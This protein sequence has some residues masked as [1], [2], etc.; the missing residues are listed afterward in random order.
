MIA[1]I[2]DFSFNCFLNYK[3]PAGDFTMKLIHRRNF[4]ALFVILLLLCTVGIAAVFET[5]NSVERVCLTVCANGIQ[6]D[7]Y[8]FSKGEVFYAFL[9]SYAELDNTTISAPSGFK[10]VINGCMYSPSSTL[11]QLSIGQRYTLEIKSWGGAVTTSAPLIIEKSANI[12]ALAI[13][14]QDGVLENIHNNKEL[15]LA[16]SCTMI[17]ED[18]VVDYDGVFS[19]LTGRGNS[20]WGESEKKAYNIQF[21]T[22][23]DLLGMG[24]ATKYCLVSN[25]CDQSNLRNKI[26]YD[27]SQ[28][29]NLQYAIDSM[30]VD[31]YIDSR[32]YGLYLLTESIEVGHNRVDIHNLEAQT[33]ELNHFALSKYDPFSETVSEVYRQGVL[34]P[35]IPEDVTGGYL[36]E[37]EQETRMYTEASG[38]IT[39]GGHSFSVKSPKYCSPE[40]I[41]YLSAFCDE[42]EQS[43]KGDFSQYIDTESWVATYMVRELLANG[44]GNSYYFYKDCDQVNDKLFAGPSWDFDMSMGTCYGGYDAN[45]KAFRPNTGGWA[46]VLYQN[47]DFL[48]IIKEQYAS[49]YRALLQDVIDTQ[50]PFYKE[51]ISEAHK[52]NQLRWEGTQSFPWCNYYD[53]LDEHVDYLENFLVKRIEFLDSAW[54]DGVVYRRLMF[55]SSYPFY[56]IQF[57]SVKDGDAFGPVTELC[58]EGYEFLGYYNADGTPYDPE[59]QITSNQYFSAVW[60]P[61]PEDIPLQNILVRKCKTLLRIIYHDF[62]MYFAGGVFIS[63]FIFTLIC[64]INN[65]NGGRYRKKDE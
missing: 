26:A 17:K 20:S 24:A 22:P 57:E 65:F 7:V 49:K 18:C 21:D 58:S 50:L 60:R 35:N 1:C 38:F 59:E 41:E 46:G 32:Y 52:M 45:P 51:L 8:L 55:Q 44:D 63:I 29:A 14:L 43:L 5:R 54:I 33:Q 36:F 62:D 42:V 16:G 25:A 10:V 27:L 9:P 2:L 28:K 34:I 12:P 39:S 4:V 11:E 31:L 3:F 61:L 30:F 64:L 47:P 56:S 13:Q 53:T 19:S 15:K 40:Q 6:E 23:V 48:K 37:A